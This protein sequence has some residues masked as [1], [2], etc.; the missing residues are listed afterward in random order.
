[1]GFVCERCAEQKVT[2]R[3][4]GQQVLHKEIGV[5]ISPFT[6]CKGCD[7]R[8]NAVRVKTT[9]KKLP[10][11]SFPSSVQLTKEMLRDKSL[12]KYIN[13]YTFSFLRHLR[14]E[15]LPILNNKEL[16]VLRKTT[17]YIFL[18]DALDTNMKTYLKK[19]PKIEFEEVTVRFFSD[20]FQQYLDKI[21][22]DYMIK[23]LKQIFDK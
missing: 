1:M 11:N 6:K 20:Y 4:L 5:L 14:Y 18:K 10:D 2:A 21:D 19:P 8:E 17:R 3:L 9:M 22:S 7:G 23:M 16:K 12:K 15:Y 13:R